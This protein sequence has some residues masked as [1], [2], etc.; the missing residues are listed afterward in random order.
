[1]SYEA[2][3]DEGLRDTQFGDLKNRTAGLN[4]QVQVWVDAAT[5]LHTD[6]PDQAEKDDVIALR[7]QFILDLR[8]TLGV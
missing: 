4:A 8:T 5:A 7:D 2:R 1:M 6:S 3:R